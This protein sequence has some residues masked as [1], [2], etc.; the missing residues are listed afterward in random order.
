VSRVLSVVLMGR[1]TGYLHLLTPNLLTGGKRADL[2]I[3]GNV[4]LNTLSARSTS[5]LLRDQIYINS[6]SSRQVSWPCRTVLRDRLRSRLSNQESRYEIL[7]GSTIYCSS[8]I[9]PTS[10]CACCWSEQSTIRWLTG[11][12]SCAK[13][14]RCSS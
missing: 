6:S 4:V 3:R 11:L 2:A 12:G 13:M 1:D 14:T 9:L 10:P 7:S 8:R 5:T